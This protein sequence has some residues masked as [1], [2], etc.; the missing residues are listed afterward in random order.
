MISS[1]VLIAGFAGLCLSFSALTG[2]ASAQT[3]PAA[4]EAPKAAK[5]EKKKAP[6]QKVAKTKYNIDPKFQ[7][8][9][10]AFSGYPV[11]TIVVDPSKYFLYL[12]ET[13]TTARRYGIA[14]GK[15]GL[16]FKGSGTIN[17]KREWPRWIPTADMVKRNPQHYGRI[18]NGM[19]GGMGNPL[20]SRALYLFQGNKDT[21]IRIHGTVQPWTIGSAASNGCFRM[22]NEDVMELYERVNLGATVVVL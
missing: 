20:G 21:Y 19:D 16:E 7:A 17:A 12:V 10:V 11:G 15:V 2:L 5:S 13:P 18:K 22:T 14:V 6:A 1:R 3:A 4:E 8:Q 9:T